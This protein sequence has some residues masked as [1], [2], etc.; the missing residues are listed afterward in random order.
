MPY[1]FAADSFH[2]KKLYIT[3]SSIEVHFLIEVGRFAF[4]GPPL[5]VLRGNVRRLS[6]AYWKAR[7]GLPIS[8]N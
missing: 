5:G 4:L 1:N 7:S 3:L 8:V 6:E 2:T